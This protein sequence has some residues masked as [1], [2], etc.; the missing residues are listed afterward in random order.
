[1]CLCMLCV[2][3][4]KLMYKLHT[5]LSC[6]TTWCCLILGTNAGQ[7]WWKGYT[8]RITSSCEG[9]IV[10]TD[11]SKRCYSLPKHWNN[12]I[13]LIQGFICQNSLCCSTYSVVQAHPY[14]THKNTQLETFLLESNEFGK[15]NFPNSFP[16]YLFRS[17]PQSRD[18]AVCLEWQQSP[19]APDQLQFHWWWSE[20]QKLFR[21][22]FYC[23][24]VLWYT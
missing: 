6:S 2:A 3:T 5:L 8:C 20:Q 11:G 18:P 17:S 9:Y 24:L 23:C 22:F 10:C 19:V 15:H 7:C 1:M 16:E 14:S 12:I 4:H 21:P 13:V